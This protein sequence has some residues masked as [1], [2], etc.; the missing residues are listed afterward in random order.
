M[1]RTLA[2]SSTFRWPDNPPSLEA[3][4][5]QDMPM[6][7]MG[8][9]SSILNVRVHRRTARPCKIASCTIDPVAKHRGEQISETLE[10]A[11]PS[12]RALGAHA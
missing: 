10:R 3:R 1:L 11:G 2:F 8:L 5:S 6:Q 4:I 9:G 7:G 12:V